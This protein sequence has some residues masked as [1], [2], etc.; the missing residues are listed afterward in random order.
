MNWLLV[1]LL[2]AGHAHHK[3]G[4]PVSIELTQRSLGGADYEVTLTARPSRD[5]DS[6]ELSLDG[7]RKVV[8]KV[9]AKV[10]QTLTA[11]VHLVGTGRKVLGA[12]VVTFDGRRRSIAD[13]V[14]IGK[15]P[16]A[17]RTPSKIIVMPDGTRVD[18]VRP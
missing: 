11:R 10:A 7:R 12:A 6:L 5:V 4:A 3:P 2:L 18:E 16:A 14:L 15:E 8:G 9:R 1:V 13:D 17:A